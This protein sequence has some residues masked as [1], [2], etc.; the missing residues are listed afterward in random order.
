MRLS[1]SLAGN[2]KWATIVPS[3]S[4]YPQSFIHL[5]YQVC[6]GKIIADLKDQTTL[7]EALICERW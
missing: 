4:G 7:A 5:A 2:D 1:L 3:V 6:L